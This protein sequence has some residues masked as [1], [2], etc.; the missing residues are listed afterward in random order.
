MINLRNIIEKTIFPK[1]HAIEESP[2]VTI[3]SMS[4]QNT[5]NPFSSVE[6]NE[7]YDT[8][9]TVPC[10]FSEEPEVISAG[11]NITTQK[12]IYFYIKVTDAP[13]LNMRDRFVFKDVRYKP[14]DLQ[15]L[16]GLWKVKVLKS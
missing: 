6:Q 12:V 9:L 15:D 8:D 7:N 10:I 14:V 4:T 1:L 16:F 11:N 2:T 3:I 5:S 13:D